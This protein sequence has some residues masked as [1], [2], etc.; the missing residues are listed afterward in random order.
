MESVREKVAG[1]LPPV[2]EYRVTGEGTVQEAFD[3]D[4]KGR[5]ILKVAGCRVANGALE[6]SKTIRL[7]R[8]GEI[9]YTGKYDVTSLIKLSCS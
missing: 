8:G 7:V 4:L 3:I 6:K 2:I 1:L 9:V 5:K